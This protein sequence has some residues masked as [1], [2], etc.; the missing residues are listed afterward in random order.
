[1][2]DVDA[3]RADDEP[4]GGDGGDR[5]DGRCMENCGSFTVLEDQQFLDILEHLFE[6]YYDLIIKNVFDKSN[7]IYY[8]FLLQK[9]S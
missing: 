9:V 4:E 6:F 7:I 5:G 8:Y 2:G 3:A 1:V